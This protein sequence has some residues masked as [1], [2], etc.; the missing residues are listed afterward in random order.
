[1]PRPE[2]GRIVLAEIPDPQSRNPKIRPLVIVSD[3]EEI[4]SDQGLL[5]VGITSTFPRKLPDDCVLLAY[6]PRG[7]P[8]TGLKK[9]C[10]AMCSWLV[11]IDEEA[12]HRY[13]GMASPRELEQ[14]LDVLESLE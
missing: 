3:S 6:H 8:R 7:H 14:I 11:E 1:V 9:R 4:R 2:Q 5:C 10:A 12:V 13:I